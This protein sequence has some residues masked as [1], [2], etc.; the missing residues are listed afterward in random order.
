MFKLATTI[1]HIKKKNFQPP[2]RLAWG[3]GAGG[4]VNNILVI[5]M[6]VRIFKCSR[7]HNL[8]LAEMAENSQGKEIGLK[9]FFWLCI[10]ANWLLE[11]SLQQKMKKRVDLIISCNYLNSNINTNYY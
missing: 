10:V 4:I 2:G 6:A 11:L 3:A 5:V 8:F 7:N 1:I 9:I